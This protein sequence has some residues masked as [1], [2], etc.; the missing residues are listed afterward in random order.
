MVLIPVAA[1]SHCQCVHRRESVVAIEVRYRVA[2]AHFHFRTAHVAAQ[3]HYHRL[4]AHVHAHLGTYHHPEMGR[5]GVAS[6]AQPQRLGATSLRIGGHHGEEG[7]LVEILARTPAGWHFARG[8]VVEPLHQWRRHDA[9]RRAERGL[10]HTAQ[11][12]RIAVGV[13][14]G[15]VQGV[16]IQSGERYAVAA[17]RLLSLAVV[18]LQRAAASGPRKGGRGGADVAGSQVVDVAGAEGRHPAPSPCQR[19]AA[20]GDG[21]VGGEPY[22]YPAAVGYQVDDARTAVVEQ[23]RPC[24]GVAVP[25]RDVVAATL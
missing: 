4:C 13:Y 5:C 9:T 22:R 21:T 2:H 24:G 18:Q 25:H 23:L 3:A 16:G 11:I 12:I 8:Q 1:R 15:I 17:H 20:V 14:F 6:A 7:L 10:R 19:K